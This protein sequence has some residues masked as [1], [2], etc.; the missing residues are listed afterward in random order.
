MFV[1]QIGILYNGETKYDYVQ[2][3]S[4]FTLSADK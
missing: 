4:R 2:I 3:S 1:V